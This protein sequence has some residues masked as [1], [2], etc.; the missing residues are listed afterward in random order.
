MTIASICVLHCLFGQ[1][2]FNAL[3][4][5]K[6]DWLGKRNFPGLYY[7]GEDSLINE[8][9]A[10]S[11]KYRQAQQV[12]VGATVGALLIFPLASVA[13]IPLANQKR[14]S[15]MASLNSA[16]KR[17]FINNVS[18][19]TYSGGEVFREPNRVGWYQ[20]E[21]F[22]VDYYDGSIPEV[23]GNL[24]EAYR[25]N[26]AAN[27]L[28]WVGAASGAFGTV[29]FAI[30]ALYALSGEGA[31]VLGAGAGLVLLSPVALLSGLTYKGRARK[32]LTRAANGWYIDV[33]P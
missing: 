7:N 13:T 16:T 5:S 14:R 33:V 20:K 8:H 10:N 30:G 6:R 28:F 9:L 15:A 2:A 22:L 24:M 12:F 31:G 23:N 32:A 11:L 1:I 25:L 26:R 17:W 29:L 21:N 18:S 4:E 27:N 3:S 19:N